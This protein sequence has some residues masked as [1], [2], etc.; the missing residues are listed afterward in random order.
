M[1]ATF[2]FMD[3]RELAFRIN[4][5]HSHT[6]MKNTSPSGVTTMPDAG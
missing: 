4:L 1:P 2:H 6:S 5:T 3:V